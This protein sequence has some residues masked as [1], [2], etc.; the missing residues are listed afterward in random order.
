MIKK[1]GIQAISAPSNES[2]NHTAFTKK[3]IEKFWWKM[4]EYKQYLHP[5]GRITKS[6]SHLLCFSYIRMIQNH[7]YLDRKII[8]QGHCLGNWIVE[9]FGTYIN[10]RFSIISFTN[11]SLHCRC[12][13]FNE[14]FK[15]ILGCSN[16]EFPKMGKIPSKIRWVVL[17]KREFTWAIFAH[18]MKLAHQTPLAP[19]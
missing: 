14:C 16:D 10:M 4:K 8:K 11:I 19:L 12:L 1:E 2:L 15:I 3:K 9:Y 13:L 5:P 17:T 18:R 7:I 6:T